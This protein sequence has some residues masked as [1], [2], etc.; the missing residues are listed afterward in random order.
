MLTDDILIC[1][2]KAVKLSEIKKAIQKQN[3]KTV[4]DIQRITGASTGCGRC[5]RRIEQILESLKK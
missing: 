4:G 5:E 1:K 2:C 3:A